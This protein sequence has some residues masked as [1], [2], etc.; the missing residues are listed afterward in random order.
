MKYFLIIAII[1]II[2]LPM[3]TMAQVTNDTGNAAIRQLN[4]GAGFE[5]GE[6]VVP[7]SPGQIVVRIIKVVL[8]ILGML[9]TVLMVYA[10][11]LYLTA[12]GEEDQV[13]KAKNT[14]KAAIIGLIIIILS[15][16]ITSFVG[17]SLIATV[18]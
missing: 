18:N 1:G 9:F 5:E 2:S 10:G 3:I 11:F 16:A 15:Y 17:N 6:D 8:S 4:V 14:I 7:N 13:T 12:R